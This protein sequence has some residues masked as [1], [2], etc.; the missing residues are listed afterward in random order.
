[1]GNDTSLVIVS[2]TNSHISTG[3]FEMDS[4]YTVNDEM[5]VEGGC[6]VSEPKMK[7]FNQKR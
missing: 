4:S 6:F 1:M 3:Y 7:W 2:V 5:E